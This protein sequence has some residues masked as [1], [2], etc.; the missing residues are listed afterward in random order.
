MRGELL[1][2]WAAQQKSL[3]SNSAVNSQTVG[4]IPELVLVLI[5]LLLIATAVALVTQRLRISY[6]AGLVLAGLPITDLLSRRIGLNPFLVLNLFLPI[7]IFEAAINT[8]ISRLRSTFKP[9]ALLAGPGSVF[10]AA[11]IAVLVKFGLGLD[12]IPALLVGV[13]L[14]NTDTVS[15]IAVFKEIRVPSRLST[16]VEGET[17]FNDAAALVTFNLLLVI[18]ATGTISTTQVIEE[19]LIVALGGGLV[20]AV[21]GYLCLPIYVRLRD[22]LSSLLLTVALALGAFQLGQ[23][24]GV[25]GAVAVVIAGLVFGNLGLPR[26]A[27][28]S[29][30][31]TLIS[32][33]EYAG[34]IVNTFIF[35]LIGIEINPLTLWQTLPS[36]VLVILAYQLGRILSVYS[37]LSV[38]RWIDRPIPLRWQHILILGN[39]KGSLSMALAVAIPLA[40]TGRELIIE[41]VF[42]AVLFSLVIQG[43]ALPWLIKKL[44]ISQVSAV[45]REIGQLQLQLIASKA[46]QDELANLL[47]SGV[48]P[49]AV[50]EELWASYQA[51]VA[52]SERLL[53]DAYNQSRSGQMEPNYGQL[54]A[55]RRRLFLAEKAALGDALR[56]RIVPEDLVQSYVK[57]LDE[58][59]LSLDDD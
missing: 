16:I 25:S 8:D 36:I 49:K 47:K 45:T 21:L 5:L 41:L 11:I 54:D 35:L 14:A 22:P 29:D 50:Y 38:L 30:R 53:R 40:L 44:D 20:G 42:G 59:L 57:G 19:V 12:W 17:L 52:V 26:S 37:L 27:S 43:L 23:F 55:I 6:V 15:I 1:V 24:L 56:K 34:F 39:I 4:D 13:I 10:S 3:D 46:A 28:A 2:A 31:I 18:Y 48:L 33:W 32:F 9:I 7:L 51:K 58:K